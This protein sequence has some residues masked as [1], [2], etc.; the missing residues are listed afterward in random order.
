MV[1]YA[2][3][4]R[5]KLLQVKDVNVFLDLK[6]LVVRNESV[7]LIDATMSKLLV[8]ILKMN[9]NVNAVEDLKVS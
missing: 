6:G 3:Q 1:V 2:F 4:S 5:M 8:I 9:R 7:G